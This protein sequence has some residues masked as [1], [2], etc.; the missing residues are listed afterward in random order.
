MDGDLRLPPFGLS[1]QALGQ[2]MPMHLWLDTACRIR[3]AGPTMLKLMGPDVLGQGL[4]SVFSLRVPRRADHAGALLRA[5]RLLMKLRAAPGTGFKGVAVPLTGDGG[6]L[7][8]LSFGYAVHDAVR[9]H[10]LSATDFAP[11]DLAIE[12][13]YLHEA[14]V[15]VMGEVTRMADRLQGAKV[16]AEAQAVTDA[17]TGL[18]N[19]RAMEA[20]L[21]RL[22]ASES[23]FALMHLDLD[24][25]KQVNDTLGHAA[26]DHVLVEVA[27]RLRASVR[28]GDLVARVG[29]DEFVILLAGVHDLSPLQRVGALILHRM[30]EP[31][32]FQGHPCRIAVSMGAVLRMQGETVAGDHLMARADAAL[33]ASKGAGRARLTLAEL[34]GS[35]QPLCSA[36]SDN[37]VD[38]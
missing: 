26:G 6:V 8:N 5:Q 14:K 4:D 23:G 21:D 9:D 24:Y 31:I 38:R 1:A 17:L 12:L 10:G 2:L 18:G 16:R 32:V 11:T 28:G 37:L 34:D 22:L 25:F 15:A 13:L 29:G 27:A 19:R 33:Y 30:S 35:C 36:E 3:G 7:L 20:A